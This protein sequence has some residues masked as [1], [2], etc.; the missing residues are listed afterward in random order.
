MLP[1][2]KGG[3]VDPTLKVRRGTASPR[4]GSTVIQIGRVCCV[5]QPV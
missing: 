4:L 1:K 3:V 5:R 2:D